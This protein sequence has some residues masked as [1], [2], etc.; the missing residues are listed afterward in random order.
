[1]ID[2]LRIIKKHYGE[3]MSHLC[4]ELFPTLLEEPGYLS[5]L[6]LEK[7]EPTRELYND[8]MINGLKESFKNYIYSFSEEVDHNLPVTKT[9]K[10]L[11]SEAGYDLYECKTEADIQ[12][13]VKYYA[14]GEELCTFSGGRLSRCYVFFAV[15]RNADK[16][17]RKSFKNPH[18]QDEYGTSVIS[19]QF[20]R[21]SSNT[22]SIKNRYNHTVD[23]PDATF[24]N[25]LDNIILG[26]TD[27]FEQEYG[28]DLS[29]NR[30][31][32]EIPGYTKVDG[33][34]YKYNYERDNVYY[35]PN[36]L[37]IDNNKI[38]RDYQQME[39]YIIF[40][41]FIIDLK[42]K[43]IDFYAEKIYTD[44]R[45]RT[46]TLHELSKDT[47]LKT[48]KK[49]KNIEVI[50]NKSTGNKTIY[51]KTN[52]KETIEIEIN[53]SN[54]MIRYKN[55]NIT[56]LDNNFLCFN[57][58]LKELELNGV[59]KIGKNCLYF[60]NSLEKLSLKKIYEIKECFMYY[61]TRLKKAILP[62]N[63]FIEDG[64]LGWNQVWDPQPLGIKNRL[65]IWFKQ[66]HAEFG[67]IVM[68]QML[69]ILMM[70]YI[71]KL[72]N[73]LYNKKE[74]NF[75]DDKIKI[76]SIKKSNA[77]SQLIDFIISKTT[78]KKKLEEPEK[79]KTK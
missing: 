6:L 45:Y 79:G 23:N 43:K 9:P 5:N 19:I 26:L 31:G 25:N 33:K 29:H 68:F 54:Q 77:I 70:K 62:K 16:L 32:F 28:Y 71:I 74:M 44:E 22:V 61:N 50:R 66:P 65:V 46:Y 64:F 24:S 18:R 34:Y 36:N 47:F 12:K 42:E 27:S 1:M 8:I 72:T 20:A 14:P 37:I 35:C 52:A 60:N 15:K 63:F 55:N 10:E 69:G 40:D 56:K 7:F 38:I 41:Y 67:P 53:S 75:T 2:D 48:I 17:D 39:R 58:Y 21:G 30:S 59:V 13:F 78:P 11:L 3:K 76:T 4:R 51:I 73:S 49:I 57:R